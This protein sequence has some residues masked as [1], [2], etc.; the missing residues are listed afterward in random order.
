MDWT[1]KVIEKS[2]RDVTQLYIKGAYTTLI[3]AID[4]NGTVVVLKKYSPSCGSSM[5]YNGEFI[6]KIIAGNRVTTA[7]LL[8]NGKRVIS[9]EQ[10]ADN[11]DGII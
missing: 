7:L 2:G 5:I 11:F 10:F 8:I 9:E 3:K 4:S 6:G 1:A